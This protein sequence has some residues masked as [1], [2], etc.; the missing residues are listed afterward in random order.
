MCNNLPQSDTD[1]C[2]IIN[3]TNKKMKKSIFTL[4][5]AMFVAGSILSSCSSND[6]KVENAAIEVQEAK[7]EVKDAQQDLSE[8]Q[9]AAGADFQQFKNES[10]QE[11]TDNERK[12]A[13]LRIEMKQEKKEAR[14]KYE[15]KIDELEQ[16]NQE[17]KVKLEAYHDDGKSDW[18]EFK[19][20]VKHDLEGIGHAFK[21]ITVR[22]TK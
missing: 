13:D 16:K 20:E 6:K 10:N 19:A 14:I 7:S 21:D 8:A 17:L 4:A 2:D 3:T 9:Q 22:N 11:L 1:F 5:T 18:K 15:K 12:I